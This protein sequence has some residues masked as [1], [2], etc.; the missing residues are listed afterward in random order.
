MCFEFS[1]ESGDQKIQYLNLVLVGGGG[2]R[3]M[4]LQAGARRFVDRD[5]RGKCGVQAFN[6]FP[7]L[8]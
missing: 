6:M 4:I 8:K 2:S 1:L 7:S 3:P 5:K